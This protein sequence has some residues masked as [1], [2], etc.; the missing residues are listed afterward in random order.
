MRRGSLYRSDTQRPRKEYQV[1]IREP[2]DVARR[3]E[4]EWR[5]EEERVVERE[6]RDERRRRE[7]KREDR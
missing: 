4:R 2:S 1:E 7:K 3:R 5:R 6:G